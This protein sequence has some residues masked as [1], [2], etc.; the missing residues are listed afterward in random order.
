[1]FWCLHDD[2]VYEGK[3]AVVDHLETH[4]LSMVY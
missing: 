2:E 1:M 4:H 3:D